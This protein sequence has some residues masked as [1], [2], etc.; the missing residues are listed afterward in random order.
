MLFRSYVCMPDLLTTDEAAIYLRLSPRKLYE[1]PHFAAQPRDERQRIT[2]AADTRQRINHHHG[3]Q[4]SARAASSSGSPDG[5]LVVPS[6]ES[7]WPTIPRRGFTL[8][9]EF[10]AI[11]GPG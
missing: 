5:P 11:T 10:A 6:T 3:G 9:A 4:Q 7:R 8:G 1:L 2:V